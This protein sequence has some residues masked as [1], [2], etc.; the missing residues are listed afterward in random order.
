MTPVYAH[1]IGD[2]I[3]QVW[4]TRRP[5]DADTNPAIVIVPEH[6]TIGMRFVN[7]RLL[8][9][10]SPAITADVVK[11]ECKRRILL[12]YPVHKQSNIQANGGPAQK[13]MIGWIGAM[14]TR[15]QE[16]IAREPI[17]TD[18]RADRWWQIVEPD[19]DQ[20]QGSQQRVPVPELAPASGY[21]RYGDVPPLSKPSKPPPQQAGAH[22]GEELAG[23]V[24]RI[25]NAID[26]L[27]ETLAAPSS[28]PLQ[29]AAPADDDF[30][31]YVEANRDMQ[32]DIVNCMTVL[33][34]RLE[35]LERR[36]GKL[37]HVAPDIARQV[38]EE[39]AATVGELSTTYRKAT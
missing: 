25:E 27:A 30:S 1:L 24:A 33:A 4:R 26:R 3:T 22:G 35:T 19:P 36:L 7:G 38:F 17:P 37:E 8:P 18:Y 14:R 9:P 6:A 39:L 15:A 23:R 2:E 13:A 16:L 31:D 20:V 29:Q 12:R 32:E 10:T 28:E 34:G 5:L 21:A 11:A